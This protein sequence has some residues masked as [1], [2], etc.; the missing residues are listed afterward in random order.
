MATVSRTV[1]S[2]KHIC[3]YINKLSLCN[4]LLQT[5]QFKK[6]I[7][8]LTIYMVYLSGPWL[9][10][11]FCP[12]FHKATVRVLDGLHFHLRLSWG[13]ICFQGYRVIGRIH[14][15]VAC[16]S[17]VP[18]SYRPFPVPN[19]WPS[20]QEVRN[21]A[22]Y[23]FV[24]HRRERVTLE[25]QTFMSC[26]P[27]SDLLSLLPCSIGERQVTNPAHTQGEDNTRVWVPGVGDHFRV[28]LR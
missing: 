16:R 9:S 2:P 14:F 5:S 28:C 8:C 21:I 22:A 25:R 11:F 24:A 13:R 18:Q 15:F 20:L 6:H 17:W 19:I 23:F 3:D 4:K 26:N 27:E 1:P 7:Y 12:E 10:W